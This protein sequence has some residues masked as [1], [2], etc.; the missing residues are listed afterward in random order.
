MT[1]IYTVMQATYVDFVLDEAVQFT[2]ASRQRKK[3]LQAI[4]EEAHE[5]WDFMVDPNNRK[6]EDKFPGLQQRDNT[7][8]VEFTAAD[9]VEWTITETELVDD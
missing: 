3:A 5:Q 9:R 1:K 4:E 6:P 2:E 8:C 7:Y